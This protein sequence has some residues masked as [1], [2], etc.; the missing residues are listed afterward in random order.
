MTTDDAMLVD[1][2]VTVKV[3]DRTPNFRV[4]EARL[5]EEAVTAVADCLANDKTIEFQRASLLEFE[6]CQW[7]FEGG[8]PVAC[9][10][11]QPVRLFSDGSWSYPYHGDD[12]VSG[13]DFRSLIEFIGRQVG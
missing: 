6:H 10:L 12:H 1:I 7:V 11:E 9:G 13:R 5:E 4:S 2:L 8:M 3:A